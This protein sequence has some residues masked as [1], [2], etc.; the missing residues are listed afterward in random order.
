MK[1]LTDCT[2]YE[3]PKYHMLISI[4]IL[5]GQIFE[6][7]ITLQYLDFTL[8]SK[9]SQSNELYAYGNWISN[10]NPSKE[11]A[12]DQIEVSHQN[13]SKLCKL[14]KSKLKKVCLN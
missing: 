8:S 6:P 13:I 5:W 3:K 14:L 9:T 4:N 12:F 1:L 2:T 10:Y 7:T 11:T